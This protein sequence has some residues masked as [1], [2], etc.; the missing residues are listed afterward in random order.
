M[1]TPPAAPS[2]PPPAE[3]FSTLDPNVIALWRLTDGIEWSLFLSVAFVLITVGTLVL[4]LGMWFWVLLAGW[5]LAVLFAVAY[6]I[7]YPPL[8]YRHYAYRIDNHVIEV[9]HGVWFRESR[10]IPLSRLQHIDLRQGPFERSYGLATLVFHT[11]GMHASSTV[12][13]GLPA[14][15]AAALRNRLLAQLQGQKAPTAAVEPTGETTR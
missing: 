11:A 13:P 6:V 15:D 7:R 8:A 10:L 3:R 4:S 1:A 2:D 9:G 14:A 12:L 5:A